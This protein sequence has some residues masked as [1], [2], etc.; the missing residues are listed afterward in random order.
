MSVRPRKQRDLALPPKKRGRP[1][2][3]LTDAEIEEATRAAMGAKPVIEIT[4]VPRAGDA[5]PGDGVDDAQGAP[6]MSSVIMGPAGISTHVDTFGVVTA[7]DVDAGAVINTGVITGG[8]I[9]GQTVDALGQ[10]AGVVTEKSVAMPVVTAKKSAPAPVE[11]SHT[12]TVEAAK[13]ETYNLVL[14]GL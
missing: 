14:R 13:V 6:A 2:K 5:A 8:V 12:E 10:L 11:T 3:I 9:V 4:R 7:P 1:K